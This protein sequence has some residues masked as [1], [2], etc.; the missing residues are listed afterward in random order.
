[1]M[2]QMA[3]KMKT[4]THDAPILLDLY[5]HRRVFEQ[6]I[7]KQKLPRKYYYDIYMIP[8]GVLDVWRCV[9]VVEKPIF[10]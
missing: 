5:L 6:M 8:I 9:I 1:M 7:K 10:G 2:P 3:V 4:G